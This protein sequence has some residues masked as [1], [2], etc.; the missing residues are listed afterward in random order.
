M[1]IIITITI[2]T[3]T[4]WL[5]IEKHRLADR[6]DKPSNLESLRNEAAYRNPA[7]SLV[8]Q[9]NAL[10]RIRIKEIITL[11]KFGQDTQELE[12][13]LWCIINEENR[14]IAQEV[15][16][17]SEMEVRRFDDVEEYPTE[18]TVNS[19]LILETNSLIHM[20]EKK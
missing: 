20:S 3:V 2:V 16:E 14:L 8:D 6:N 1:E 4:V 13:D 17:M 11:R 15:E 12:V 5:V 9:M 19:P 18:I 7:L 10:Y